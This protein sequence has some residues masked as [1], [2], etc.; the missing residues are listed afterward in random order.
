M[1]PPASTSSRG[2]W[3]KRLATLLVSSLVALA[4]GEL[5]F[6]AYEAR[7][8]SGELKISPT[9]VDLAGM[10]FND[11][12]VQRRL[13]E[14]EFRVLSF[15]DSF[16]QTTVKYPYSYHA[17]AGEGLA[18]LGVAER[19]R[20]V[21]LGEPAISFYQYVSRYR[22]WSET[23]EHDAALFNVYLGNDFLEVALGHVADE[24]GINRLFADLDVN[25]QTGLPRMKV[26]HKY[27][28]RIVDYSV[29]FSKI[30]G[31]EVQPVQASAGEKYTIVAAN[32]SEDAY[33]GSALSQLD[34]FDAARL[35]SL[36]RGYE[37]MIAFLRRVAE[38]RKGGKRVAVF[39]SPSETQASPALRA[40]LA[41]RFGVD[42]ERLDLGLSAYLI[43]EAARRIDPEIPL[44]DL[45]AAFA[46]GEE[47]G[48]D[49]Y[50]GTNTHWSE[51]GDA[52]A[53]RCL[54]DF[55]ARSWFG[56]NELAPDA[57][58]PD[59]ASEP[60]AEVVGAAREKA[61]AEFLLPLLRGEE[62]APAPSAAE[63]LAGLERQGGN[64]TFAI[65]TVNGAD[66]DAMSPLRITPRAPQLS[67]T[68]WAID[69]QAMTV[70]SGVVVEVNG[71]D[72]AADY[73]LSRS[74]VALHYD[75]WS[76]HAV[77]YSLLLP[78]ASTPKGP[79]LTLKVKVV[80]GDGERY[81]E[82]GAIEFRL[83]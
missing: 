44:L 74:D 57:A 51:E 69:S 70:A 43:R 36:R 35:P 24:E 21:N 31:G 1:N 26:P 78:A 49:L 65:T 30:L 47:S 27:G 32:L 28:L 52:L 14:G 73:G 12:Q 59:A 79:T 48:Q 42:L 5:A 6:R 77:G 16:A 25:T 67:V 66:V 20:V 2:E 45:R 4:L 64:T 63:M 8:L 62:Q 61:L 37:A 10:N 46:R 19:V 60:V 38:I 68:G 22:F 82:S 58:C 7:Y 15:G 54:T 3:L 81:Y 71:E 50:L 55:L 34:N 76:L 18:A 9:S 72:F 40:E 29:A 41:S 33:Y 17:L 83:R 80:S 13:G 11:S 56:Q 23:I 39:L 53:G 75:D